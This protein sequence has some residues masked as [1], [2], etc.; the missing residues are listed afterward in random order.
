MM[1]TDDPSAMVLLLPAYWFVR[2]GALLGVGHVRDRAQ[3]FGVVVEPLGFGAGVAW[4]G[5]TAGRGCTPMSTKLNLPTLTTRSSRVFASPAYRP[6]A[7]SNSAHIV[8]CVLAGRTDHVVLLACDRRRG[9]LDRRQFA[10]REVERAA[11][12]RGQQRVDEV[13]HL[14]QLLEDH[15]AGVAARVLPCDQSSQDAAMAWA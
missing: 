8:P 10:D 2:V 11:L 3:R 13:E 12:G 6:V 4:S 7:G 9:R 5:P 1:M 15:R 14:V